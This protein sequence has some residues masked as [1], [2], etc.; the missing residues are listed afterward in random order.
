MPRKV[1]RAR[2]KKYFGIPGH[3]VNLISASHS[4]LKSGAEAET[5][6][7]AQAETPFKRPVPRETAGHKKFAISSTLASCL[8]FGEPSGYSEAAQVSGS[9]SPYEGKGYP[10]I[11]CESLLKQ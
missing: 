7:E 2:P 9:G 11:N 4:S 8:S 3:K 5:S 1:F 10:L 6:M